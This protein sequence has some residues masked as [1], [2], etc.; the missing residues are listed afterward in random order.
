MR[1]LKNPFPAIFPKEINVFFFCTRDAV[2]YSIYILLVRDTLYIHFVSQRSVVASLTR[3][4]ITRYKVNEV[5]SIHFRFGF[6]AP[7]RFADKK[8]RTASLRI[9][10]RD[11]SRAYG[12]I[13]SRP[14]NRNNAVERY[15]P[16]RNP[17]EI[18]KRRIEYRV[19]HF[20][21]R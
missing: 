21:S 16:A 2:E 12:Y 5:I 8:D 6:L 17:L 11:K 1:Y 3:V 9:A 7:Q 20:N 19:A 13:I 18:N 10:K 4:F 14:R 15:A